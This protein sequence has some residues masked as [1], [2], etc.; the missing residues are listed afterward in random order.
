MVAVKLLEV[1]VL[2]CL[3]VFLVVS[4]K[5]DTNPFLA[6]VLSPEKKV[7]PKD[8]NQWNIIQV[9]P[10]AGGSQHSGQP[11]PSPGFVW[12]QVPISTAGQSQVNVPFYGG[13][14]GG[15]QGAQVPP[16]PSE[17][18]ISPPLVPSTSVPPAIVGS[19]LN[20]RCLKP[21]GQFPS[22]DCNK[23]VNC[24]DGVATE[25]DCPEGL[26][27]N[28]K[29]YCD[30]AQN[31]NC[32]GKPIEGSPAT[33]IFSDVAPSWTSTPSSSS[34]QSSVPTLG[35]TPTTYS[36]A[37]V[38]DV[39]VT[40][41]TVDPTLKKKCLKP[42]G[43]FPTEFCNKY[44]NCWDDSVT[45]QECPE[46]LLF[47]SEGY[48]D[49]PANVDC[50][51]RTASKFVATDGSSSASECPLE[52][53]T[54]RNRTDCGAYYTC[55]GNKIA[56]TYNCHE[57][58]KYNDNIGVCDYENRVDCSKEPQIFQ[59][60]SSDLAPEL[61]QEKNEHSEYDVNSECAIEFGTFRDR[62][63]CGTYFT[64]VARKIVSKHDC[65]S[66]FYFNDDIGVCDYSSRVDCGRP[67]KIFQLR[68]NNIPQLPTEYMEKV[69][70]CTPGSVFRLNPQCTAACLQVLNEVD[71][72]LLDQ[73][74]EQS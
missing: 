6:G 42:R 66:G 36:S 9:S 1:F 60:R 10:P 13:A 43:Q 74:L 50:E 37:T 8:T 29:G 14:L 32:D 58:F 51:D 69:N 18:A 34:G 27:F 68:S 59:R 49:Y 16:N 65:P 40:P 47:S 35:A 53:G 57:G 39:I 4:E 23:F 73:R 55:I 52:Y 70:N 3:F 33:T 44:V 19:G 48:C 22:K 31:V 2:E 64:C 30:H 5:Y 46:G 26:F 54:F 11:A 72:K 62:R 41:S 24:W 12:I 38:P 28:V 56:A 63:S 15:S 25:Q 61:Q 45:E 21:R 71:E 67:P 17:P 7:N 20:S